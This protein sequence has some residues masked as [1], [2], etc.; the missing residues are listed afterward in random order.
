MQRVFTANYT[1]ARVEAIFNTRKFGDRTTCPSCGYRHKF[2]K[3]SDG[4]WQCKRCD[5]KFGLLTG[6]KVNRTDFRLQE[7]YE[8]LFWFELELTDH[9]IAK[10]ID[11]NY[12]KIHRFYNKVRERLK[13]YEEESINLL[14]GEV[15]VDETYFGA[16]FKNRR[17]SKREKLRKE[18][19]VKRGRG[20]KDLKE[21]VFGIYER[22]DGIVYIKP[23]V[24]VTKDTL[25]EI[26]KDKVNIETR[27]YSDTWKSYNGL[28][29]DF[30]SHRVVDHGNEEYKR[31]KATINGIEGF[32]GYAKERLLKHHGVSP[33]N[34]LNY[35]KEK[36][37]RFNHRHLTGEDFV[38][39]MLEVLLN[40]REVTP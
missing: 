11:G 34:F 15:E 40:R 3:L 23:V 12:Q 37:Y 38:N 2:Y 24:D 29:D 14:D 4:R 27:I 9:K 25:Q 31:G 39:K 26:I 17:R 20:A 30:K 28:E 32:W 16:D 10:R 33:E 5:K 13:E 19:R 1:R 8:L 18:G 7:I 22:E 6:T 36:E 35:L 21:A